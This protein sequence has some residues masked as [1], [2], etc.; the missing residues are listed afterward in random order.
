MPE[1]LPEILPTDGYVDENA[2]LGRLVW[3]KGRGVGG[4]SL[5]VLPQ[6]VGV[7]LMYRGGY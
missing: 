1:E 3:V 2:Q 6:C 7:P 4:E 5:V